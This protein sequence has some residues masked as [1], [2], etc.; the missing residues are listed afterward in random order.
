MFDYFHCRYYHPI[1]I[2]NTRK[3]IVDITRR[4]T[5]ERKWNK[6]NNLSFNCAIV[7]RTLIIVQHHYK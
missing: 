4:K 7:A 3:D 5:A 2:L 6:N 1:G